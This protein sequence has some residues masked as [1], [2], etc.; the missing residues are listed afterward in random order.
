MMWLLFIS[1]TSAIIV[2][3]R[4]N[5]SDGGNLSLCLALKQLRLL[6]CAFK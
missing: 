2:P 3:V 6:V 5:V 4:H 1:A